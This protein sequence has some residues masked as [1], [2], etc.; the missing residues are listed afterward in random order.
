M[1]LRGRKHRKDSH[2]TQIMPHIIAI[3]ICKP[4]LISWETIFPVIINY[5]GGPVQ[6]VNV[7]SL[8][9]LNQKSHTICRL[10]S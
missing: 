8:R 4:G 5:T 7:K 2:R 6:F 3:A 9:I 10:W 1:I